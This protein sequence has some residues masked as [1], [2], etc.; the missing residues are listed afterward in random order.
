MTSLTK[1]LV[2]IGCCLAVV[3]PVSACGVND[4]SDEDKVQEAREQG[5]REGR[6]DQ[7]LREL[8]RE[9]RKRRREDGRR[10]GG[11][12]GPA[13]SPPSGGGSA[14]SRDCGGGLSAN[15]VTTCAFAE[16]VKN[17]YETAN[18]TPGRLDVYSPATG[19]T[20]SMSCSG[21][22]PTVCTGGNNAAV[23]FP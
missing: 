11:G 10:G 19:K 9:L 17:A 23:Y 14:G 22:S 6:N 8:E 20:Y 2:L 3:L 13:P 4:S 12:S 16:N 21:G 15:S 7:R 1:K 18:G 5:Q